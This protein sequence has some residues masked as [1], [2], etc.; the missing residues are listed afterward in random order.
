MR[1]EIK[2]DRLLCTILQSYVAKVTGITAKVDYS[3]RLVL[4]DKLC[5]V[6]PFVASLGSCVRVVRSVSLP[7][8]LF[9]NIN[10]QSADPAVK[11]GEHGAEGILR[12]PSRTRVSKIYLGLRCPR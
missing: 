2:A 11:L 9:S 5:D 10:F 8:R 3:S 4:S 12:K 6:L 1:V 7:N